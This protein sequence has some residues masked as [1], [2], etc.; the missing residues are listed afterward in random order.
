MGVRNPKTQ[1][2]ENE[3]RRLQRYKN[4]RFLDDEDNQTYMIAQENLDSKE[5]TIRNNQY[6]VVGKPLD[7]RDGDN[8]DP[9]ISRDIN[10]DLMVLLKGVEQDPDLGVKIV[11]PSINDDSEATDSDKEENNDENS[12]KTPYNGENMNDYSDDREN[13]DDNDPETPYD[14]E[15][16]N[17]SSYDEANNDEVSPNL[18]TNDVNINAN[19]DDEKNDYEVTPDTPTNGENN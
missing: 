19:S 17:A 14:G 8:L 4:I 9:L 5:P 16:M 10:D 6:C 7:R 13:N 2:Q 15:N 18:T 11:H 12:P 3:Q 1:Y